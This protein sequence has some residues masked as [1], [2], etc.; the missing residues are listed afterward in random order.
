MRRVQGNWPWILPQDLLFS[1]SLS[2]SCSVDLL[3]S[4]SFSVCLLIILLLLDLSFFSSSLYTSFSLFLSL[5]LFLSVCVIMS[6]LHTQWLTLIDCL[7]LSLTH[8]C[9]R[10]LS[11]IFFLNLSLYVSFSNTRYLLFTHTH[12]HADTHALL[13]NLHFS[14]S[15]PLPLSLSFL[16]SLILS[17]PSYDITLP[18]WRLHM[19]VHTR[20]SEIADWYVQESRALIRPFR[21]DLTSQENKS[22]FAMCLKLD[23]PY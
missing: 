19:Y 15:D 22:Y 3:L 16:Q 23:K 2:F 5:S 17:P 1:L 8:S 12:K 7:W 13:L 10:R 9:S 4:V 20:D 11:L 21:V 18:F 14:L 6:V